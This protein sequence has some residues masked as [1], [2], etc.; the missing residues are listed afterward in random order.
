MPDMT[1]RRLFGSVAGAA[2]GLAALSLLPSSVQRAVAAE[3]AQVGSLADIKHVVL[4]RS[5]RS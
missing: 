3:P 5:R 1:R 4:S 2:G